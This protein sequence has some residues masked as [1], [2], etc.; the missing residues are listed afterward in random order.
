MLRL[1]VAHFGSQGQRMRGQHAASLLED[2]RR[3]PELT[4]VQ[5]RGDSRPDQARLL[6][7]MPLLITAAQ[8]LGGE[9]RQQLNGQLVRP[10]GVDPVAG[11]CRKL[12]PPPGRPNPHPRRRF[13]RGCDRSKRFERF[14]TIPRR[15][16]S[17][18]ALEQGVCKLEVREA[19][20]RI[21]EF[22][23]FR[24]LSLNADSLVDERGVIH[25]LPPLPERGPQ[26]GLKVTDDARPA[27]EC[28][29]RLPEQLLVLATIGGVA[30]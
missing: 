24:R 25:L 30:A 6:H 17:L 27:L 2:L 4:V 16:S 21:T 29:S 5:G 3:P 1:Q 7:Q 28:R 18:V 8:V 15:R 11:T 22:E 26:V 20:G 9:P 19:A 23:A 10:C 13:R 12:T 14:R